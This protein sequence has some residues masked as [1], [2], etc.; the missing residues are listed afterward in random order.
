M[1]PASKPVYSTE[2]GKEVGSLVLCDGTTVTW[3]PRWE[4]YEFNTHECDCD[5]CDKEVL[6]TRK[7]DWALPAYHTKVSPLKDDYF[8]EQCFGCGQRWRSFARD[9][10]AAY[11]AKIICEMVEVESPFLKA[12]RGE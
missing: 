8:D 12:L 9:L 1:K 10:K 4:E 6:E 11:P 2:A 7:S 5:L 3:A